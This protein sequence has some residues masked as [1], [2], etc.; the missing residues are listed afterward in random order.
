M[1]NIFPID[2]YYDMFVHE[3][4]PPENWANSFLKKTELDRKELL[5]KIVN[6]EIPKP[7]EIGDVY[8]VRNDIV[9]TSAREEIVFRLASQCKN[10]KTYVFE[11]K[12]VGT[13]LKMSS[14]DFVP[15]VS[16]MCLPLA[17]ASQTTGLKLKD[18]TEVREKDKI[19]VILAFLLKPYVS[20]YN[21]FLDEVANGMFELSNDIVLKAILSIY[22]KHSLFLLCDFGGKIERLL[23]SPNGCDPGK[24]L[25]LKL[26]NN[27]FNTYLLKK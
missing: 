13:R 20:D 14:G 11:E 12:S 25:F 1:S 17:L 16:G 4:H 19:A 8:S 2:S 15:G 24:L 6:M 7:T 18:G 23:Y 27:H 3:R 5:E 10:Q 21:S 22:P 26:K 9:M